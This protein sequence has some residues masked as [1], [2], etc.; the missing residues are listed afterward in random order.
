MLL[1]I[2][3]EAV[4]NAAGQEIDRSPTSMPEGSQKDDMVCIPC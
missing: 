2:T 3:I 4:Y 1:A